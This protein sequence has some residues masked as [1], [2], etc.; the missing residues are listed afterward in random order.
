MSESEVLH[1]GLV[2]RAAREDVRQ[3]GA[4]AWLLERRFPERWG[5]RDQVEHTGRGGGPIEVRVVYEESWRPEGDGEVLETRPVRVIEPS[6]GGD[7]PSA[8]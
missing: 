3:W 2:T 6:N 4:A 1:L 7:S 8:A 5:R